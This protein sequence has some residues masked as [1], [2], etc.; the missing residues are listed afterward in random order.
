MNENAAREGAAL[1]IAAIG[2]THTAAT[3]RPQ[4]RNWS[5]LTAVRRSRNG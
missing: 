1:I 3:A 2:K 4:G 5:W